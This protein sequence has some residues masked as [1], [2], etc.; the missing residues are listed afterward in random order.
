MET[1]LFVVEDGLIVLLVL[2]IYPLGRVYTKRPLFYDERPTA[3]AAEDLADCYRFRG[4]PGEMKKEDRRVPPTSCQNFKRLRPASS[5]SFYTHAPSLC[6]PLFYVY[7]LFSS[8]SRWSRLDGSVP[9]DSSL[10]RRPCGRFQ[11]PTTRLTGCM[12]TTRTILCKRLG[13]ASTR[14]MI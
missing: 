8:R 6:S 4:K 9:C 13:M 7:T 1:R 14:S 11:W 12:P 2:K 5:A 10:R 3:S